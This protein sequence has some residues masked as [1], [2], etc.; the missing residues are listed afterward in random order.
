MWCWPD[1]IGCLNSF[2]GLCRDSPRRERIV[3]KWKVLVCK[4]VEARTL[5]AEGLLK[6]SRIAKGK[7]LP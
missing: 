1:G 7:V 3:E 2:T 5:W 6:V 4:W